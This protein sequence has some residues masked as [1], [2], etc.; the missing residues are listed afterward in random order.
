MKSSEWS[1]DLSCSVITTFIRDKNVSF[2]SRR[3]LESTLSA[4]RRAIGKAKRTSCL[5]WD[6]RL[7]SRQ[8]DRGIRIEERILSRM[9]FGWD[10][11][12]LLSIRSILKNLSSHQLGRLVIISVN[13]VNRTISTIPTQKSILTMTNRRRIFAI[14]S[15]N[16]FFKRLVIYLS[17]LIYISYI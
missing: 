9:D 17:Y 2:I 3:L 7:L 10:Y 1:L 16:I 13:R 11:V 8:R 6:W 15:C 12:V 5:E 14:P 4:R